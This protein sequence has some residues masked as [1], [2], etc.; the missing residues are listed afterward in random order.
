MRRLSAQKDKESKDAKKKKEKDKNL[1][2]LAREQRL[3]KARRNRQPG[4]GSPELSSSSS[5]EE[6]GDE[7][8]SDDEG[9]DARLRH[10]GVVDD[11]ADRSSVQEGMLEVPTAKGPRG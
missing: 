3:A 5:E 4:D 7:E 1:R 9:M 8:E 11:R 10:A 2:R 6:S